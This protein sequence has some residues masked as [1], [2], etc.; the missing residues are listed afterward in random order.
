M[1]SH[2]F[3]I[4]SFIVDSSSSANMPGS[5]GMGEPDDGR[6]TTSPLSNAYYFITNLLCMQIMVISHKR[7]VL[8]ENLLTDN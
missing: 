5:I 2:Y 1:I 6:G 8:S 4:V 3:S 7:D